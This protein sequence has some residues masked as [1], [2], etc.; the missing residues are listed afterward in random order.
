MDY[1]PPSTLVVPGHP[2]TRAKF[3]FVDVHNHQFELDEEKV[4][5]VVADM[6][7]LNMAVMVNLSGRGFRRSEGPDGKPRFSLREPEHLRGVIE[8][9]ERIAPGRMVHFTNV[10]FAQVGVHEDSPWNSAR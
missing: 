9:T 6:D 4:R 8:L 7:A 10:D 1:D 2:T 5:K 3:P